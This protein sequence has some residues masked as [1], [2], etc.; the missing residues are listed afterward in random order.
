MSK[1]DAKQKAIILHCTG[2]QVCD[3]FIYEENEDSNDPDI[4]L[5]KLHKYCHPRKNEELEAYRFLNIAFVSSYLRT[6]A[7]KCYFKDRDK[8][9]YRYISFFLLIKG[10]KKD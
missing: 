8:L 2:A 5:Q 9:D 6:E 10:F 3:H 7:E 1:T 4:M